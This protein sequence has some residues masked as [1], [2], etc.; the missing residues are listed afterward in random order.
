MQLGLYYLDVTGPGVV[1]FTPSNP[2][3][4]GVLTNDYNLAEGQASQDL[5]LEAARQFAADILQAFGV[6]VDVSTDPAD[7]PPTP[8]PTPEEQQAAELVEF[9]RERQRRAPDIVARWGA[10]NH[11]KLTTGAWT[12]EEFR[13]LVKHEKAIEAE[14]A[15]RQGSWGEAYSLLSSFTMEDNPLADE[16]TVTAYL[17]AMVAEGFESSIQE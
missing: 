11:V 14:R 9:Y 15:V 5:A 13:S 3:Y 10:Y 12:T 2:E 8:A 1:T 4:K 6:H 7:Y 17:A 16:E